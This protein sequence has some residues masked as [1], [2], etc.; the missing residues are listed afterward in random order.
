M[1]R[2]GYYWCVFSLLGESNCA[3]IYLRTWDT[4]ALFCSHLRSCRS[5]IRTAHPSSRAELLLLPCSTT[6][7]YYLYNSVTHRSQFVFIGIELRKILETEQAINN[8]VGCY[9]SGTAH[10]QGAHVGGKLVNK[11]IS[12]DSKTFLKSLQNYIVVCVNK[13]Q[14]D[15]FVSNLKSGIR[16]SLFLCT[17]NYALNCA[18]TK[19]PSSRE[20]AVKKTVYN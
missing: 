14:T 9:V 17:Q 2:G 18:Y 6:S 1:G 16:F 19:H 4:Q 15:R 13:T 7:I 11:N 8:I 3:D 10:W 5:I 12:F 20:L